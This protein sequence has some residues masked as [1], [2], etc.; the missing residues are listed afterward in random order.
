[1]AATT[2]KARYE[3]LRSE[4]QPYLQR[5]Q[6]NATLT[7][8]SA[9]PL[10]GQG[11]KSH[12][13][14]PYQGFGSWAVTH[15][16]SRVSNALLPASRPFVRLSLPPEALMEQDGENNPDIE[17]G[18]AISE[19]LIQQEIENKRWRTATVP[20]LLQLVIAGN[21]A[22][23][24]NAD[25]TLRAYKLDQ[26][27]VRL[28]NNG[29]PL[30]FI[31]EEIFDAQQVREDLGKGVVGSG[32]DPD[33]KVSVFTWGRRTMKKGKP[34]YKIAQY[35]DEEVNEVPGSSEEYR[36]D[37]LPYIFHRWQWNPG[38]D[39]GRAK[40][41]DHAGDLRTLEVLTKDAIEMAAMA[42][43]HF[44][45]V[46]PGAG[47]FG[48][49]SQIS[50]AVNG[51]VVVGNPDDVDTK[52]F[53]QGQGYQIVA[54]HIQSITQTLSRGFLLLTSGQ[55]DAERV[56]A[57]EIE[58][59]IDELESALGG[60]FSTLSQNMLLQRTKVLIANMQQGGKLPAWEDGAIE[61][62]I[63]T[64]LEALSRQRDVAQAQNAAQIIN[65][66]GPQA[67]DAIKLPTVLQRAFI[68][69]GMA[70]AVRTQEEMN[71]EQQ[72][73][74]E[75]RAQEQNAVAQGQADAQAQ[76]E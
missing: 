65:M 33:E 15:L 25:N 6:H 45:M 39:Y 68:G 49:K 26:Y 64:G 2:A 37:L 1:M 40:V 57:T 70:D 38:E 51:D 3:Q 67:L 20:M 41:S 66:F 69:L 43:R 14:E 12:L 8:P 47:G 73:Q 19:K 75:L 9:M 32:V 52:A 28:D 50:K 54:N 13:V 31:I 34:V 59:D 17:R 72:R 30:E 29:D 16:S 36:A 11:A 18:L 35:V 62:V 76:Q 74:A 58:R 44:I 63:L 56:T 24:M 22:E 27:V 48:L 21:V 5:A 71:Q 46:R 42:G 10:D 60:V 61:P 4:R 7:I 23:R 53:V 55:R